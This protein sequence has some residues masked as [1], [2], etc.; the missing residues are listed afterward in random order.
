MGKRK[1][2]AGAQEAGPTNRPREAAVEGATSLMR[3]GAGC[4]PVAEA[5]A[6]AGQPAAP[7]SPTTSTGAEEVPDDLVC[8]LCHELYFE[9]VAAAGCSHTYCALCWQR[10]FEVRRPG[11]H[12]LLG[13]RQRDCPLCRRAV[14]LSGAARV[15]ALAAR[16]GAAYPALMARRAAETEVERERLA[17]RQ[18]LHKRLIVGNTHTLA[19]AR[20][21]SQ[22]VHDWTFYVR[23][24]SP[25][26]EARFIE[27]VV[28]RL[29]PTF[30]PSSLVLT[31]PPFAVRRLGW[32]FFVVSVVVIFREEWSHEA[33]VVHW[34][35][36][37]EGSGGSREV[38]V[39]F[40]RGPPPAAAPPGALQL[41]LPG[42]A[43]HDDN[44]LAL[45]PFP[46]QA[47]SAGS[48]GAG[49]GAA[50]P[51]PA[52]AARA[53]PDWRAAVLAALAS[54]DTSGDEDY[55]GEGQEEPDDEEGEGEEEEE[56]DSGSDPEA[57]RAARNDGDEG[58]GGDYDLSRFV[59]GGGWVSAAS[60]TEEDGPTYDDDDDDEEGGGWGGSCCCLLLAACFSLL[61]SLPLLLAAAPLSASLNF[62][63]DARACASAGPTNTRPLNVKAR[64]SGDMAT[65]RVPFLQPIELAALLKG[66]DREKVVVLDVRD[67]DEVADGHIVGALNIPA[68]KFDEDVVVDF[69]I[70]SRLAQAEMV[71]VHCYLSQQRG[72]YVARRIASRLEATGRP[73]PEVAV[74]AHGWRRFSQV[75]GDDE[76][77]VLDGPPEVVALPPP[78]AASGPGGAEALCDDAPPAPAPESESHR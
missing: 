19:P 17:L 45:V 22:N 74:L 34:M 75:F 13:S 40:E 77:L 15:E 28:V 31:E 59:C 24:E 71:V 4:P 25:E 49:A 3:D 27:R 66:P 52:T 16:I 5:A 48:G 2:G 61:A 14:T 72:P 39:E 63:S 70:G 26:D 10:L 62:A 1:R 20:G 65:V 56:R 44:P 12:G 47:Q 53:A 42:G 43:G 64:A 33:L 54:G 60:S 8:P 6:E 18:V 55:R 7:V 57:E 41:A 51:A 30:H 37:F 11:D 67:D 23:M 78:A 73:K 9:P 69:V 50:P 76:E 46:Y 38:E 32:G 68:H 29:H 35:L 58:V 21:G 36:E